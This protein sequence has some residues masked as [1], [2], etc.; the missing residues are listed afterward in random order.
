MDIRSVTDEDGQVFI[1]VEDLVTVLRAMGHDYLEH[2]PGHAEA[3]EFMEAMMDR[4][5][6]FILGKT[7]DF[8]EAGP[9]GPQG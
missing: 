2:I 8:F 3:G 7:A 4:H 6:D 5:A 1:N 9:G